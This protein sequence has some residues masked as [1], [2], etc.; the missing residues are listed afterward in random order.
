MARDKAGTEATESAH[1]EPNRRIKELDVIV[2]QVRQETPDT[3]TLFF[4][5]GNDSLNYKAGHFLTI[6]PHQ[7]AA[8]KRFTSF[9]EDLKGQK[10]KSRA[11][12][13]ASAPHERYLSITIKEE[14]YAT[15][16]TPYPPLISPLLTYRIPVGTELKVVGFT[17]AYV[18]PD[19]IENY[20]DHIVH[21]CAGSGIVPNF[22][23]IKDSLHRQLPLRH[24]LLYSNKT[25]EE[26]IF[27]RDFEELHRQYPDKFDVIYCITRQDPSGVRNGREGRITRELLEQ[28]IP[29]PS[30]GFVFTCG[31]GVS[32]HERK[33]AREKG[34]TPQPRFVENMVAMLQDI[35][36]DKKH[37]KQESWG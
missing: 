14:Y 5:I 22:S 36:L 12:S 11:Y 7:F 35:G 15:G 1:K 13:M 30:S 27:Y 2:A 25:L 9:L 23:I 16:E 26:T 6:D 20:T 32:P 24:T 4:F 3:R 17:G 37:I 10:E 18:L 19:D 8:L 33:A 21:V 29:D 31:P 34:E 28:Y